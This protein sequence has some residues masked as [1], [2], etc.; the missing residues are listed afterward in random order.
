M[1]PK[2]VVVSILSDIP[3]LPTKLAAKLSDD[4]TEEQLEHA[5]GVM[6][7]SDDY[8]EK[9]YG[10]LRQCIEEGWE[11]KSSSE[12]N[13]AANRKWAMDVLDGS[14]K[15][16]PVEIQALPECLLFVRGG[17]SKNDEFKYTTPRFR[18]VVT[19]HYRRLKRAFENP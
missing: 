2:P 17:Q 18:D 7:Q 12:E 16:G 13:V 8:I 15:L 5:V 3:G 1:A 19:E 11:A 10:W 4:Y 14:K 6:G 9:P